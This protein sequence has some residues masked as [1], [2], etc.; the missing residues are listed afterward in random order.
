L[1]PIEKRPSS[2]RCT[3]SCGCRTVSAVGAIWPCSSARALRLTVISGTS[4]MMA[5]CRVTALSAMARISIGRFQPPQVRMVLSIAT[6][7]FLSAGLSARS[8]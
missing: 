1:R 5:P 8:R 6:A 4:A 3:V 2:A 7:K